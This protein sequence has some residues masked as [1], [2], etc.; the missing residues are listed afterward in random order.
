MTIEDIKMAV[1]TVAAEFP[2]KRAVLFG[3]QANG[4]STADSDVDLI[5]E[6]SEPITLITLGLIKERIEEILKTSVDIIHGPLK[7]TDMIEVDKE[8]EVYAA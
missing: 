2:I 5:M 4:T 8:I 6:F 7:D 1:R 3:S